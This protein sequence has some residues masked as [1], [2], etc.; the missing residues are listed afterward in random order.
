MNI[1]KKKEIR[2]M[3]DYPK[4]FFA[5][6]IKPGVAQYEDKRLLI[7]NEALNKMDA[8]F[9]RKPVY[10]EHQD[11]DLSKMEHEAVGYVLK[12]FLVPEDGGAHWVKMLIITDEG[13]QAVE[14]GAKVSNSY[15]PLETAGGGK[16]HAVD[17]DSEVLAGE[18]THL[19]LT[20]SPRYEE[21]VIMTEEEFNDFVDKQKQQ[22]QYNNSTKGEKAMFGFNTKKVQNSEE[23]KIKL[24]DGTEKDLSEI[25]DALAK[26]S[27]KENEDVGERKVKVGD[28]EMTV[29]DAVSAYENLCK[30]AE[31]GEEVDKRKDI[32]EIDA[33]MMKPVSEFKGGAEEKFRTV[34]KLLEESEYARSSRDTRDNEPDAAQPQKEDKP[35]DKKNSYF[36]SLMYP[37]VM[38]KPAKIVVD[39]QEMKV[40]RG[41]ERY[42]L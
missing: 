5:R 9:A 12:S 4:I 23:V 27:E 10:I 20:D 21:A 7:E 14:K 29:K 34:T 3:A 36:N 6:H 1:F 13:R 11:V 26:H 28:K 39:T 17:Y 30:N 24:S 37:N 8:S 31:D 33:I 16:W 19:A 42:S 15:T 25:V 41:K 35:E 40:A 38:P 18:Y 32:R 2:N 22:V